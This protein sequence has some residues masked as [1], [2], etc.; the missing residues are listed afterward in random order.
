MATG[1]R[2]VQKS[3][4]AVLCELD[5]KF[6]HDHLAFHLYTPEN[7]QEKFTPKYAHEFLKMTLLTTDGTYIRIQKSDDHQLQQQTYCDHKGYCLFKFLVF[8]S[9]TGKVLQAYGPFNSDFWH[10][11]GLLLNHVLENKDEFDL[12]DFLEIATHSHINGSW[13]PERF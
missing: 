10:N 1:Q 2:R 8:T 3:V 4:R 9:S 5:G 11:D 7:V 13:I 6:V 12:Y